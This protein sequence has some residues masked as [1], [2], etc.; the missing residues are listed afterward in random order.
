MWFAVLV[1]LYAE[2]NAQCSTENIINGPQMANFRHI[3]LDKWTQI[4]NPKIVTCFMLEET[5][6]N[7]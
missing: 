3:F 1:L 7:H 4:P 2:Q 5:L 6:E